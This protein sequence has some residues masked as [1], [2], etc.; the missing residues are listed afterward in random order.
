M[1]F[2]QD[3]NILHC[4]ISSTMGKCMIWL[5]FFTRPMY[6]LKCYIVE[7]TCLVR[8]KDSLTQQRTIESNSNSSFYSSPPLT[9]I[10]CIFRDVE[11]ECTNWYWTSFYLVQW[12]LA[13]NLLLSLHTYEAEVRI[14]W[15][16]KLHYFKDCV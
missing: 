10:D 6:L 9:H 16:Q 5:S 4:T 14:C 1:F 8:I 11:S 12:F 3:C 13:L 7:Q 2:W 15:K